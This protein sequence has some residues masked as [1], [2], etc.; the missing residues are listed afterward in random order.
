[1]TRHHD[2][3]H[4]HAPVACRSARP[5]PTIGA[6]NFMVRVLHYIALHY[7]ALRYI[8]LHY[9]ILQVRVGSVAAS[10]AESSR[11]MK[12]YAPVM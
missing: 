1:M 2:V 9:I 8:V 10:S 11:P 4:G 7:I 6:Y 5:D 12:L 3:A